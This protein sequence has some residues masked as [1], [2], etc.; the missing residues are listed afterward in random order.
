MQTL[1]QFISDALGEPRERAFGERLG[2][3]EWTFTSST[4]MFERARA[5]AGALR[6]AGIQRG[7]RV[8]LIANNRVDWIAA[9]FGALFAGAVVVP[10][11][12]TLALDPNGIH[13]QRFRSEARVRGNGGRRAAHPR[14]LPE[15]AAHRL[16]R[17]NRCRLARIVRGIGR[18]GRSGWRRGSRRPRGFDLHV[19]NH[20]RSQRRDAEPSQ[21]RLERDRRIATLAAGSCG[22]RSTRALRSTVRAYLRAHD[23]PHHGAQ[24]FASARDDARLSARG[25]Q[26]GAAAR[27]ESRATHLR[28]RARRD[29]GSRESRRGPQS[30][31]RSVGAYRWPRIRGGDAARWEGKRN[32]AAA[33]RDRAEA[34]ALED[35]AA[36]RPRS[37][38]VFHE[39]QRPAASGHHA[40]VRR[41]GRPDCRGIRPH[42]DVAGRHGEPV[43]RDSLR[44]GRAC[45]F[46]RP[47]SRLL[48]TARSWSR[49]RT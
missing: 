22:A 39:R 24:P 4:R 48:R 49:V 41:H 14:R 20:G 11:F 35:Q 17:W 12:S 7:D 9:D 26:I 27:D 30:K 5:I 3:P 29:S 25:S 38:R 33:V 21:P 2:A 32:A 34:G 43:E 1:P 23:D 45:D 31:A 18:A 42:R 46:G 15:H 10:V 37:A 6:A 19:W 36:D 8:A 28:A 40:D 13:L 16:V 44:N 47:R